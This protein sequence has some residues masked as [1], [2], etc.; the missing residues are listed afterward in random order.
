MSIIKK[1]EREE[2][3]KCPFCDKWIVPYT[4]IEEKESTQWFE[5]EIENAIVTGVSLF[6]NVKEKIDAMLGD[7]LV[8]KLHSAI[9]K[10]VLL[11]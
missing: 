9:E 7:E 5:K 10:I 4:L 11:F 6:L 2:A 1:L 3:Q 8:D